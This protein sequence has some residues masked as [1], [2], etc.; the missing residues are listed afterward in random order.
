MG[1]IPK[2]LVSD[3]KRTAD[4]IKPEGPYHSSPSTPYKRDSKAVKSVNLKEK[5]LIG[6]VSTKPLMSINMRHM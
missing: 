3:P 2:K 6:T 1:K 5:I 4:M